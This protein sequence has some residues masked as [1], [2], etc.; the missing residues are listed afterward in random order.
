MLKLP[1]LPA[2]NPNSDR[3]EC[4][5]H[6]GEV[7]ITQERCT[8]GKCG[9]AVNAAAMVLILSTRQQIVLEWPSVLHRNHL[10]GEVLCNRDAV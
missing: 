6:L 5:Y 3:E 10:R 1:R 4:H 7:T 8:L 2:D 9:R